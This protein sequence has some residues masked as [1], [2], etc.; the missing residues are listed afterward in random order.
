MDIPL[1]SDTN[2]E[3]EKILSKIEPIDWADLSDEDKENIWLYS[4][5]FLFN[6]VEDSGNELLFDSLSCNYEFY[7]MSTSENTLLAKNIAASINGLNALYKK[8]NYADN[9][10][11]N[12]TYD[13]ACADFYRIFTEQDKNVVFELLLIFSNV[14]VNSDYIAARQK[15]NESDDDFY[16]RRGTEK[17]ERFDAFAK[18]VSEIF[19]EFG[20]N[21]KL[22][23]A[24]IIPIDEPRILTDIYQPALKKLS[25]T[26][27]LSVNRD[28]IDAFEALNKDKDGSGALT[29][30]LSAVQGFLQIIV[31]G[32]TGNG[33][34]S[35]LIDEAIKAG[36]IS[37][38][39]SSKKLFKD[40]TSF[41]ARE[42]MHRG[43]P[44]PKKE[45]A[46]KSQAMLVIN[47]VILF[48]DYIL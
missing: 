14:T 42:R 18:K 11:R 19:E 26:K 31:H 12:P 45:Y 39:D 13:N 27:W 29:H 41:W 7:G 36:L 43:D 32:E 1:W 28:L 37:N 48:M 38:D 5:K 44:H 6:P 8:Q 22:T 17:W 25:D 4:Q 34:T 47:T 16:K 30:A 9:F 2:P 10:L 21:Y 40:L 35:K 23:R 20:L 15:Q 3:I 33:D 46:T 24:G